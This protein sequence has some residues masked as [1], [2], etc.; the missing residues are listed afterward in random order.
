MSLVAIGPEDP[1]A[2]GIADE[3]TAQGIKVFGP[4]KNAAKIESDKEWAKSFMDK[5]NVATAKWKSFSDA[6]EAKTFIQRYFVCFSQ[7]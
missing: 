3:L 2:N 6:I 1:L 5:Y 7:V 4:V